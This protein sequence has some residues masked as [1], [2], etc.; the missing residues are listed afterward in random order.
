MRPTDAGT[1]SHAGGTLMLARRFIATI[2][3][4]TI[5]VVA[6]AFADKHDKK[7]DQQEDRDGAKHDKN[8]D[9]Q[10]AK[11]DKH[12][13]TWLPPDLS[14]EERDEWKDGRPP[15]WSHGVKRG[16]GGRDCPPGLARKGQ[17][18]DSRVAAFPQRPTVV[19]AVRDALDR[20][21]KWGRDRR[22]SGSTL[23][24]VLVG[25]EGAV[26]HGVPIPIAERL[27]TVSAERG[28]SPYGIEAI[29]RALAYGADR[30]APLQELGTFAEHGVN[31]DVAADAIA[32]GIYRLVT[33]RR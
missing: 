33:E 27:V 18:P 24:A 8:R 2:L 5:V 7:H 11:L 1:L 25:F 13:G 12:E 30:R 14:K 15:G 3:A 22:L 28:V 4:C 26:R 32:L 16:W 31:R 6:P 23:D 19:D 17:C 10:E 9:K 20:L 29:T 21:G